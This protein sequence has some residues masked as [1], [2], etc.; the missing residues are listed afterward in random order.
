MRGVLVRAQSH[1]LIFKSHYAHELKNVCRV[2]FSGQSSR[3][4]PEWN[5]AS[6]YVINGSLQRCSSVD[7]T[8]LTFLLPYDK[9]A[10]N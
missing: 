7:Q 2:G 5:A 9:K 8:E 1:V 4:L 3:L 6:L 10:Q